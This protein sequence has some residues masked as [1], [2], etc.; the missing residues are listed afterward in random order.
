MRWR[1]KGREHERDGD[2]DD[3]RRTYLGFSV[4]VPHQ[5]DLARDYPAD[6]WEAEQ[7]RRAAADGAAEDPAAPAETSDGEVG[8]DESVGGAA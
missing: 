1:D 6:A 7:D 3:G 4:I 8:D 5:P 2:T